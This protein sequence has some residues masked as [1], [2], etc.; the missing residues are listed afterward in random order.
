MVEY[1]KLGRNPEER[2]R[3]LRVWDLYLAGERAP[4]I[5]QKLKLP[6]N[7]VSNDLTFLKATVSVPDFDAARHEAIEYWKMR[8]KELRGRANAMTT[9]GGVAMVER[10]ISD[11]AKELF[12]LM[13]IEA[14]KKQIVNISST[15]QLVIGGKEASEH[16]EAFQKFLI[17]TD[18]KLAAKYEEF[19]SAT[20][21]LPSPQKCAKC[22]EEFY[23]EDAFLEHSSKCKGKKIK[24]G[25]R[26]KL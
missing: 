17:E 21:E 10:L 19:I 8:I 24:P 20:P 25:A 26:I 12:D 23:T 7:Q 5:A 4:E 9:D 2:D 14:V 18:P 3:R 15:K 6:V 16:I 1:I 13:G 22:G 11:A